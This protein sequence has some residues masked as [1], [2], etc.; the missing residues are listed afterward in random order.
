MLIRPDVIWKKISRPLYH[1]HFTVIHTNSRHKR[2]YHFW[3]RKSLLSIVCSVKCEMKLSNHSTL[4]KE[5]NYLL[6]LV[7]KL[8]HVSK[9]DHRCLNHRI[10]WSLV[11][12]RLY[13]QWLHRPPYSHWYWITVKFHSDYTALNPCL[14]ASMFRDVTVGVLGEW[15]PWMTWWGGVDWR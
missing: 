4:C 5:W 12:A 8:I 14:V 3:W 1:V 9:R 10:S 13:L 15:S 2:W 7:L 11:A 6:V